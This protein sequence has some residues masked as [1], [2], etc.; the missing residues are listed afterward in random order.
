[1]DNTQYAQMNGSLDAT[2]RNGVYA[3]S[4]GGVKGGYVIESSEDH[5][6][7]RRVRLNGKYIS[8]EDFT[9]ECDDYAIDSDVS[10]GPVF[11]ITVQPSGG[12]GDNDD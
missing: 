2:P 5:I 8:G 12:G 7:A 1:M 3:L 4:V 11:H 10:D 6:F 9:I